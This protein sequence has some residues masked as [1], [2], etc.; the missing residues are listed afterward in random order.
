MQ[1]LPYVFCMLVCPIGMG[2]MMWM[3]MRTDQGH[4]QPT[5]EQRALPAAER[6]QDR[7]TPED[8]SP[9]SMIAS[10]MKHCLNWKVLAGLATV[11]L[12][13]GVVAPQWFSIALPTLLVLICPLSMLIML[14]AMGFS[15]RN[16]GQT[17]ASCCTQ[18][19][20]PSSE[21]AAEPAVETSRSEM[22]Q[23]DPVKY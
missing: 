12:V 21:T 17:S 20:V 22:S 2:L 9:M 19:T 11:A 23:R 16:R 8:P 7:Q 14:L 10:C 6:S 5:E 3:G 13:I 15:K 18:S 1:Y 4:S